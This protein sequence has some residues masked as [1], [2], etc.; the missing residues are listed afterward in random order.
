MCINSLILTTTVWDW[1]YCYFHYTDKETETQD[2]LPK[3][4]YLEAPTFFIAAC[5]LLPK[6]DALR[7]P[8]QR[9]PPYTHKAFRLW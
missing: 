1:C 9:P 7:S 5:T 3:F 8:C 4:T 2:E 6:P